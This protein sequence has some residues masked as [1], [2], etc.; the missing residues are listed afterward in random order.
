MGHK[1]LRHIV[2]FLLIWLPVGVH[3]RYPDDRLFSSH[4]VCMSLI[5]ENLFAGTRHN[6]EVNG[7]RQKPS[8]ETIITTAKAKPL[9]HVARYHRGKM[10]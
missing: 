3:L 2:N 7:G 9:R 1:G 6:R 4:R 5:A 8:P 10:V